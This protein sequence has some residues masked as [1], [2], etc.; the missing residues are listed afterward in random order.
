MVPEVGVYNA[1]LTSF[2]HL[3]TGTVAESG[4]AIQRADLPDGSPSCGSGRD[5]DSTLEYLR[6][7]SSKRPIFSVTTLSRGQ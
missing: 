4:E 1:G 7:L 2:N 3:M 6:D 5:A